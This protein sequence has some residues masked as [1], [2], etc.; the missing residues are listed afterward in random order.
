M[1]CAEVG[2]SHGLENRS[3]EK[4]V[5]VRCDHAPPNCIRR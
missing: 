2:S 5:I 1:E 3:T 4:S